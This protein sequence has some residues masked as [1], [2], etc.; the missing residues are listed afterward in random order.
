[1]ATSSSPA[2]PLFWVHHANIDRL[3]ANWQKR[4]RHAVPPNRSETLKPSPLFGVKV[5]AVL[6]IKALGYSYG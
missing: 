1:M 2:D 3:W 4:H 5:S 6:D